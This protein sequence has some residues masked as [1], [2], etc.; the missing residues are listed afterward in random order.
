MDSIAHINELMEFFGINFTRNVSSVQI[1][2]NTHS[3]NTLS[4]NI[5][6]KTDEC[7]IYNIIHTHGRYEDG[8]RH[9]YEVK[10]MHKETGEYIF[11]NTQQNL[12]YP[13]SYDGTCNYYK[14]LKK[15]Y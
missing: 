1:K 6:I 4:Y 2:I 5:I 12:L 13:P 14:F 9:F 15:K 7:D 8:D 3:N 10:K 11:C